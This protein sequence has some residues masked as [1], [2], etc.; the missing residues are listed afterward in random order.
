MIPPR[1]SGIKGG[2]HYR[3]SGLDW[4]RLDWYWFRLDWTFNGAYVGINY[5]NS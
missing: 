4:F 1:C 3:I 2:E 5:D